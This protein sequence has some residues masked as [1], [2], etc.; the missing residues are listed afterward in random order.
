VKDII[1]TIIWND[2]GNDCQSP[3]E[4]SNPVQG[5]TERGKLHDLWFLS[6]SSTGTLLCGEPV[7]IS[8]GKPQFL[9]HMCNNN[10][11]NITNSVRM[12]SIQYAT[13]TDLNNTFVT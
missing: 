8:S 3:G 10:L 12:D 9:T 11:L 7:H 2:R 13:G 1:L 6:S 5:W 4:D